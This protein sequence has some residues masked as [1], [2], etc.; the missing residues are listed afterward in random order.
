M[1]N[2]AIELGILLPAFVAGLLVTVTHVPLGIQVLSR[3][4]V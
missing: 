1:T 2:T 4:I 3:G